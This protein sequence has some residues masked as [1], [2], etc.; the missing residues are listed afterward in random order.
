MDAQALAGTVIDD[1][2]DGGLALAGERRGEIGAPPLGS[3]R[4][5][6][7]V[8]WHLVDALGAD[9]AVVRPRPAPP[10]EAMRRL[11]PVRAGQARDAA[12][13]G[14]DAGEAQACPDLAVALAPTHAACC[15]GTPGV[16]RV[17]GQEGA[18]G[19]DQLGVGHRPGRTWPRPRPFDARLT[20]A[21]DGGAGDAPDGKR[22]P[23]PIG[24]AAL[25]ASPA[26]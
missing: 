18:D 4:D 1:D 22:R 6:D 16:E 11:Q 25:K 9:G 26:S 12:L 23:R 14:A 7:R 2:E 19:R 17:L 8:G 21:V 10:A 5:P 3:P 15:V 24:G 13:R 20:P